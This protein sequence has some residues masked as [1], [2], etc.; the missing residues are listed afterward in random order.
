MLLPV[1]FICIYSFCPLLAWLIDGNL[2]NTRDRRN[3]ASGF[4]GCPCFQRL[5]YLPRCKCTKKSVTSQKMQIFSSAPRGG[6][7]TPWNF[8]RIFKE[9]PQ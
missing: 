5:S 2:K 6:M 4:A 1:R 3:T 9:N 8:C 7:R